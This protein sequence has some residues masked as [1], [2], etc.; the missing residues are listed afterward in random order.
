MFTSNSANKADVCAILFTEAS[1]KGG[2]GT[3]GFTNGLEDV[4]GV[5]LS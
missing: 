5:A 4:D 3:H 1:R 2:V